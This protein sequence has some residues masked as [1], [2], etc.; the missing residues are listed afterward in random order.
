MTG[1]A[2]CS[3]TT[4][5]NVVRD[6]VIV[7]T[8]IIHNQQ[9]GIRIDG[10]GV[11]LQIDASNLLHNGDSAIVARGRRLVADSHVRDSNVAF[12]GNPRGAQVE[13]F[14][15]DNFE[16][17]ELTNNYYGEINDLGELH[18][19]VDS[20]CGGFFDFNGFSVD[21]HQDAGPR[22]EPLAEDIAAECDAA[23]E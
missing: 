9:E 16:G 13:S 22:L 14:H 10:D 7:H 3:T 5:S 17:L 18:Q 19:R 20:M 12:N 23:A 1:N 6:P 21:R 15:R 2:S 11:L 8:D 4:A